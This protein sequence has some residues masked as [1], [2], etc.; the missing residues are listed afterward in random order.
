LG[1]VLKPFLVLAIIGTTASAAPD[2]PASIELEHASGAPCD[3]A[4]ARLD[5]QHEAQPALACTAVAHLAVPNLGAVELDR[6][7]RQPAELGY[8]L[9]LVVKQP[10]DTW[11]K[12]IVPSRAGCT[13]GTCIAPSL[14]SANLVRLDANGDPAFGVEVE[15]TLDVTYSHDVRPTHAKFL[16]HDRLACAA[17]AGVLDCKE[18]DIG[19]YGS[20]CRVL[21]WHGTSVRYSCVESAELVPGR[22][23]DD[24]AG[25]LEA[26]LDRMWHLVNDLD[27]VLFENQRDCSE[28]AKQLDRM[29]DRDRETVALAR[30]INTPAGHLPKGFV[31]QLEQA[32]NRLSGGSGSCLLDP[33]SQAAID[34]VFVALGYQAMK[35]PGPKP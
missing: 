24:T 19:G 8:A 13:T 21:G 10:S 12:L 25:I 3:S 5:P 6:V 7:A 1:C 26:D 15:T 32:M 9:V 35:W 18:L 27:R 22:V 30:S 33:T 2:T 11:W 29:L 23:N 34:R 28:L 4:I 31:A 16:E 17:R 14:R 20:D